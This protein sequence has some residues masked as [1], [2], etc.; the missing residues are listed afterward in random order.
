MQTSSSGVWPTAG[1][2]SGFFFYSWSNKAW[3][4]D[5]SKIAQYSV[6]STRDTAQIR[7]QLSILFCELPFWKLCTNCLSSLTFGGPLLPA[8][9]FVNI[10][11]DSNVFFA[12]LTLNW[13]GNLYCM[14]IFQWRLV[15]IWGNDRGLLH[16]KL[17]VVAFNHREQ[18]KYTMVD[19][20][21]MH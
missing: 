8:V 3:N 12:T 4:F 9:A 19:L 13:N 2:W 14:D 10:G 21:D 18:S 6:P 7:N 11:R 5:F 16:H 1:V 17:S 20:N 15:L